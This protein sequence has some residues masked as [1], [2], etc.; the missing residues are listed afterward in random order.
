VSGPPPRRSARRGY[1]GLDPIEWAPNERVLLAGLAT[2]WGAEAVRI[3][4]TTGAL[5]QLSGY[6]VDL[7]RDG[8][9][10]LVD[11]GGSERLQTIAAVTLANGRRHVLAHG[12]VAF[13]SWNR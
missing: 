8:R 7:S 1:Y 13:P 9:I 10:A 3:D 4:V 6:A 5:R 11:S 2:E 12:D